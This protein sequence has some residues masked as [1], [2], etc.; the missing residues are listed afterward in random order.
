M[1]IKPT[2]YVGGEDH[3]TLRDGRQIRYIQDM[4][5]VYAYMPICL[6]A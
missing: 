4:R 6:Y 3:Q 2:Y 1:P 5:I